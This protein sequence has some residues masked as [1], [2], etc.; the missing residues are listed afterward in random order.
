MLI[1]AVLFTACIAGSDAKNTG[2]KIAPPAYML[3]NGK[4]HFTRRVS[5]INRQTPLHGGVLFLG[6]SITEGGNWEAL[7]PGVDSRNHGVG[8]DTTT[9]LVKRLPLILLHQPEQIYILI[10]T[11]D[12]GY[13][14]TPKVMSQALTDALL[15]LRKANPRAQIYVQSV[16]PREA[17]N[18]AKVAAINTAYQAALSQPP[19]ATLDIRYLDIFPAFAVGDGSLRPDL[20]YDGLHLNEN[21]YAVWARVIGPQVMTSAN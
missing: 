1:C 18:K 9:G 21:G 2:V 8:W 4:A 12:I 16:L 15:A 3:P 13:D 14:R 10:G 5:E 19:L 6:D 11:N 17:E 7:F 20:T